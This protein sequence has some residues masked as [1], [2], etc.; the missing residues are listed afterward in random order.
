MFGTFYLLS[1]TKLQAIAMFPWRY[2]DA[3][4]EKDYIFIYA[5]VQA[6]GAKAAFPTDAKRIT[7]G[8]PVVGFSE[9]S[10]GLSQSDQLV[11]RNTDQLADWQLTSAHT[12]PPSPWDLNHDT[13]FATPQMDGG[14]L[15]YTRL[16]HATFTYLASPVFS[17][18]QHTVACPPEEDR[19]T[20][21]NADSPQ[22]LLYHPARS[23]T[24]SP[25]ASAT[26][27]PARNPRFA[28]RRRRNIA[29]APPVLPVPSTAVP[30]GRQVRDR[31]AYRRNL[32]RRA[33]IRAISYFAPCFITFA[34]IWVGVPLYL[35]SLNVMQLVNTGARPVLVGRLPLFNQMKWSPLIGRPSVATHG[36][37]REYR[38][39]R[40]LFPLPPTS[41]PGYI[42]RNLF[43][44]RYMGGRANLGPK[45]LPFYPF[46]RITP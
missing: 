34:L 21:K 31:S 26:V 23:L 4:S 11:G 45:T 13:A 41:P 32:E 16:S 1:Q 46:S 5:T 43:Q 24:A 19:A 6:F 33:H 18:T 44:H 30:M 2:G 17:Q 7:L 39:R 14:N 40:P 3:P 12:L 8:S 42:V 38:G 36:W 25:A 22:Q 27:P 15:N 35:L 20:Q 9:P 28:S 10:S 29:H 37:L